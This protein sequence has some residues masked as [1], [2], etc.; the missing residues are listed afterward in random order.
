MNESDT[1]MEAWEAAFPGMEVLSRG[2]HTNHGQGN[3]R[4]GETIVPSPLYE[5][6]G[7]GK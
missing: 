7:E 4:R 5:E 1:E 3:P 2:L 6:I